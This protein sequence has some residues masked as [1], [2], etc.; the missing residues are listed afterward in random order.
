MNIPHTDKRRTLAS[1]L[2]GALLSVVLFLAGL[3]V[4]WLVDVINGD[5]KVCQL[6]L[7]VGERTNEVVQRD[8]KHVILPFGVALDKVEVVEKVPCLTLLENENWRMVEPDRPAAENGTT[9]HI[10]EW[11]VSVDSLFMNALPIPG[12]YV[13][14]RR[15]G[16]MP[17]A[18]VRVENNNDHATYQGW[19]F[20]G[21]DAVKPV[22]L[23]L[24]GHLVL[25]LCKPEVDNFYAQITMFR[26]NGTRKQFRLAALEPHREGRYKF[27]LADFDRRQ[28]K[29]ADNCMIEIE[30]IPS[31]W[32]IV[33]GFVLLV[34]GIRGF[35]RS[36][37]F[38][39][40]RQ[41]RRRTLMGG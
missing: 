41:I 40:M 7:S 23:P 11:S 32:M 25:S 18:Y 3:C 31:P 35:V 21:L 17:A 30:M 9:V 2:L 12:G 1:I 5:F 15:P 28:G 33:L 39:R 20:T 13:S 29:W 8:G 4:S 24:S 26:N 37:R 6:S 19:I 22:N 27:C 10:G 34:L 36:L 38:L 14:R 16:A